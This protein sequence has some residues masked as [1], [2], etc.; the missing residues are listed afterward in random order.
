MMFIPPYLIALQEIH[1]LV[2]RI[3]RGIPIDDED[4]EQEES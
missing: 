4:E 3:E 2:Y 1:E